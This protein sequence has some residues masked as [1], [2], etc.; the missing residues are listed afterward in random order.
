M[1]KDEPF[2][3]FYFSSN[4]TGVHKIHPVIVFIEPDIYIRMT[5]GTKSL[6]CFSSKLDYLNCEAA[7][8]I[9]NAWL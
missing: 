4:M 8:S 7:D 9:F 5:S 3:K 6:C 2:L 1:K